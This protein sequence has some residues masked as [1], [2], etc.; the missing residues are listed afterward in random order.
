MDRPGT[1]VPSHLLYIY[2]G[3]RFPGQLP[4]F[5]LQKYFADEKKLGGTPIQYLQFELPFGFRYYCQNHNAKKYEISYE[6]EFIYR[7]KINYI[8]IIM[9]TRSA[10]VIATD[11]HALLMY[12]M[13]KLNIVSYHTVTDAE[14]TDH[15]LS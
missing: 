7:V 15:N 12:G 14:G 1:T 11:C 2:R 5:N 4:S 10:Y 8:I 3:N 6:N 9:V 13:G